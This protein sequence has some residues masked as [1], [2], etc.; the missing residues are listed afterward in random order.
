M[1]EST[2]QCTSDIYKSASF[3]F[4]GNKRKISNSFLEIPV[5]TQNT[6]LLYKSMKL[7]YTRHPP[8]FQSESNQT[9]KIFRE[10]SSRKYAI[11]FPSY[12]RNLTE[13]IS[14]SS[15]STTLPNSR[16]DLPHPKH[17]NESYHYKLFVT[18]SQ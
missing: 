9:P 17:N 6:K 2:D 5:N 10:L 18:Y 3:S 12:P 14:L 13:Y 8:R 11:S 7:C 16:V 4:T 1:T 15:R